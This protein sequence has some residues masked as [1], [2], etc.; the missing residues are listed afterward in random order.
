[1]KRINQ[2][3]LYHSSAGFVLNLAYL[4]PRISWFF[5]WYTNMVRIVY[6]ITVERYEANNNHIA[7]EQ[8]KEKNVSLV[9]TF[10]MVYCFDHC[11]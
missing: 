1:M 4:F 9:L 10:S 11:Q 2:R 8:M 5:V 6:C 7:I 3:I